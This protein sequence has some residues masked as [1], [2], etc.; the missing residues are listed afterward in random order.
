MLESSSV[1]LF[2]LPADLGVGDGITGTYRSARFVFDPTPVGPAAAELAGHVAVAEGTASLATDGGTM[3]V[4][5]KVAADFA[6]VAKS[7]ANGNID[8]CTFEQVRVTDSGTVTLTIRPSV[9]F[10]LV[11]FTGVAPGSADAPTELAAG[12]TPH[13][14]FALG[15]AQLSAYRFSFEP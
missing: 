14:A 5:F 11:D 7:A 4:H 15:L 12:T 3:V 8:G 13:T 10:N 1:D 6:D 2:A 9:W